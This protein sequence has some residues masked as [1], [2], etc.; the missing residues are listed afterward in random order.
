M[1]HILCDNAFYRMA[2]PEVMVSAVIQRRMLH[3][4]AS[5]CKTESLCRGTGRLVNNY[6]H[7]YYQ[8]HS[9]PLPATHLHEGTEPTNSGKS[10]SKAADL[11]SDAS[12]DAVV[13]SGLLRTPLSASAS[14]FQAL[15]TDVPEAHPLSHLLLHH[16]PHPH[17]HHHYLSLQQSAS[18]CGQTHPAD[19]CPQLGC[20]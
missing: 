16:H 20:P 14:V 5:E 2:W 10:C 8:M 6:Q 15:L 13:V 7:E 4:M 9:E 12:G 11:S 1:E 18:A 3:V 17:P 19:C